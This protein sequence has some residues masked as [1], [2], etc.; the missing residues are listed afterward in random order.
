M[1]S[2]NLQG[3]ARSLSRLVSPCGKGLIFLMANV[4]GVK[5]TAASNW[6]LPA[7]SGS[8]DWSNPA[9]WSGGEPNGSSTAD[10]SNGGTAFI[11]ANTA[12]ALF[13]DLGTGASGSGTLLLQGGTFAP[14]ESFAVGNG[15][16]GNF[17][18]SGGTLA[19]GFA[20]DF[21]A[22]YRGNGTVV[23]SDGTVAFGFASNLDIGYEGN[24]TY[25]LSGGQMSGGESENVGYSGAGTF[26]QSGG[27]NAAS[28]VHVGYENG[29]GL[30]KLSGGTLISSEQLYVG[31]VK[32]GTLEVDGGQLTASSL[33]IGEGISAA[34]FLQNGGTA[35]T[36]QEIYLERNSIL[37][38]AGGTFNFTS[39][40]DSSGS[41]I[42]LSTGSSTINY[43]GLFDLSTSTVLGGSGASVTGGA[44]SLIVVPAGFDPSARFASFS[45]G[46]LVHTSGTLFTIPQGTTVTA[47]GQ[48]NDHASIGGTLNGLSLT[49]GVNVSATG[50]MNGGNLLVNDLVSGSSGDVESVLFYLG[51]T[52][53]PALF[54]ESAGTLDAI[55]GEIGTKATY[56]AS[57]GTLSLTDYRSNGTID[58]ANGSATFLSNGIDNLDSGTI[59]NAHSA[60]LHVENHSLLIV[61]SGFDAYSQF[62]SVVVDSGGLLHQLGTPIVIP[63]SVS[64]SGLN[65]FFTTISDF[66]NAAG[67]FSAEEVPLTGGVSVQSTGSVS[68]GTVTVDGNLSANLGGRLSMRQLNLG[69]TGDAQFTQSGGLTDGGIAI[70]NLAGSTSTFTMGGGTLADG[71]LYVGN[72][73]NGQ[74]IQGGG[75]NMDFVTIGN[76]AGS[77]GTFTMN[78]GSLSES[79]M[80][81]GS[82]GNGTF[83]MNAGSVASDFYVGY[84]RS[85]AGTL[86]LNGG[87]FDVEQPEVGVSGNGT[88]IQ[89]G[90]T[91]K[92]TF[93]I[94]V[95]AS[96]GAGTYLMNGGTISSTLEAANES[97]GDNGNGLFRQTGGTNKPD[98]LTVG[99][100]G[101]GTYDLGG[102]SLIT[103][104]EN[105]GNGTS[106]TGNFLQSGGSNAV[107]GQVNLMTQGTYLL[108]GG[109][110]NSG[111]L[112]LAGGTFIVSRGYPGVVTTKNFSASAGG[113]ID[114]ADAPMVMN[115]TGTSPLLSI[116]NY[117]KAG[118]IFSSL[119]SEYPQTSLAIGEASEAKITMLRGQAIDATTV[120]VELTVE[121]DA[122]LDFKVDGAD[123]Q[124]VQANMG[125]SVDDWTLGDLNGDGIVN[126][127]DLDIVTQHLGESLASVIPEP[128]FGA[129]ALGLMLLLHRRRSR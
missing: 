60:L 75:S 46:G 91:V 78:G 81:V 30:Y 64:I 47:L 18:Q 50:V 73:G 90:G 83:Q 40:D 53:Q 4:L 12:S 39:I 9:N 94:Y 22:G 45:T 129:G 44:N 56:V 77:N 49:N 108:S 68:C 114:V 106:A 17:I 117:A 48:V 33:Y 125:E 41:T 110:F 72:G 84:T 61:P 57:A 74:F 7:S 115:Y 31:A 69:N 55:A 109:T 119:T 32:G 6:A 76:L 82:S 35:T 103:G 105:I 118:N 42:D 97:I 126:Q 1:F 120:L 89:N 71:D 3:G 11:S 27:L 95:A 52:N 65:N 26:L 102:G 121:G 43:S 104:A 59:V 15:G 21:Y 51:N 66:V 38:I 70:G 5:W 80:Y 96:G 14:S 99:Y 79:D 123:E 10:I 25:Q 62:G 28:F 34:M 54:T 58:F 16:T 128:V 127:S 116:K 122:N 36:T 124:L 63:Q 23:Q 85:G 20:G 112:N 24:G 67:T 2:C 100:A 101:N 111:T 93:G 86:I 107:S 88:L 98:S 37:R 87:T 92:T 29:T 13:C 113:E 19:F 8:G